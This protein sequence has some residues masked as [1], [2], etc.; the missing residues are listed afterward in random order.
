L[1]VDVQLSLSGAHK[2]FADDLIFENAT[3]E[4]FPFERVGL[5]GRNG[6][7]KTTLLKI[8]AGLEQPDS[9]QVFRLGRVAYLAQR[10]ALGQGRLVDVVQPE[11]VLQLKTQL[12]TAQAKLKHPTPENL[13]NYAELEQD[14]R[15]AGGYDFEQRAF[16][17]LSGL[18]LDGQRS[19]L[20]LSGGEE[21]RALLAR[22]LLTPS[23]FYLLDEPTNHL[24]LDSLAWLEDWI[25]GQEA[26][27]L[28]VSHDREFLD[29]TVQRCLELER[30]TLTG[31]DGNFTAA[32]S[33]KKALQQ[34]QLEAHLAQQRKLKQLH[35]ER[36]AAIAQASRS[37]NKNRIGNRDATTAS[38]LMNRAS[39]KQGRRA[40]A[41]EKRIERTQT[42]EK[43][44]KDFFLTKI[45]LGDVTTG[46]AE[47]LRLE[48]LTV[49]RG[50]KRLFENL[51]LHIRRG[52]RVALVGA[53]GSGK[54]SLLKT[55]LGQLTPATGQVVFGQG[56]S[57]YWAGQNTEELDVY[58]NLETA[59]LAA[60]PN[61]KTPQIYALLV[62]LGLPKEPSRAIKTLSG[63]QRTRLSLARLSVTQASL[64]VLDEPTNN[65]DTDAIQALEKMLLEYTGTV[66][67]ASH[68][69]RMLE[70]LSTRKITC[71]RLE[72]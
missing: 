55:I 69:R 58:A 67:F 42:I 8:L 30:Q 38:H 35:I 72:P 45:R 70:A 21:R 23:D 3:L 7:G 62:S 25:L 5:L 61:L 19:S 49:Q 63:G 9:G 47:V 29:N 68:D 28:I 53:N 37:E 1:E 32:M 26:G 51:N 17:V 60:D 36:Q 27:F 66:V 12:E 52:E 10:Q 40:L 15:V 71:A 14:F 31:Y 59:L 41:L 24:D 48:N 54:S 4:L 22:L 33:L 18:G 13:A 34:N 6:S 20:G 44:F 56:V 65:L 16:E 11:S 57:V 2:R 64:L 46:A 39:H 43:P 50:Q